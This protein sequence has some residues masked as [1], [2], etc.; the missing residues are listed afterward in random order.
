MYIFAMEM[1]SPG[2]QL[3]AS[4]TGTLSFPRS[5]QPGSRLWPTD[6]H[7]A[8]P[9]YYGNSRPHVMLRTAMRPGN[10]SYPAASCTSL[11]RRDR[12][13]SLSEVAVGHGAFDGRCEGVGGAGGR[14]SKRG[15]L[16]D[17]VGRRRSGQV[18][19]HAAYER[20]LRNKHTRHTRRDTLVWQGRIKHLVGPTH[21]TMPGPQ[22][23]CW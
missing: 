21:F 5:V 20:L 14:R 16:V 9:R 23:L 10:W 4:C 12:S 3:C 15:R 8:R 2:H 22:Y 11:E 13:V 6:R 19:F 17:A 7:T 1:A 18:L